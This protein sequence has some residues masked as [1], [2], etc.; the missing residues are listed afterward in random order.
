MEEEAS[1]TADHI[2]IESLDQVVVPT[3]E[4]TTGRSGVLESGDW[5]RGDRVVYSKIR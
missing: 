4:T 5:A 3:T 1:S 2:S